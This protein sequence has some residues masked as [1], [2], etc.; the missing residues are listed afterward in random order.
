MMYTGINSDFD[1]NFIEH[2]GQIDWSR[3]Y[4]K[5]HKLDIG[6]KYIFR[7]N[8]S[9]NSRE[10][11]GS[12]STFDD[13][14]H[15]TSIGAA[16][17]DYRVT[18]GRFSARAGLRY[19]FSRLSAKFKA[20]EGSDFGSN[21]SDFA[22][23]VA[24]SWNV[25]DANSLKISYSRRIARPGISYLDPTVNE[26]PNATHQGNP[27]LNSASQ[28]SINLNYGL[29]KSK[30]NVNANLRFDFSNDQIGSLKWYEGLHS[31]STFANIN[32]YRNVE[33]SGY[34][35][36]S[37]G[38]KTTIMLNLSVGYQHYRYPTE[39]LSLSRWSYSPY[40]YVMQRLPWKLRIN[41]A[42]GMWNGMISGVYGYMDNPLSSMWHQI[43]LQRSFLKEDRLTIGITASNPFGPST[44]ESRFRSVNADYTG[45]STSYQ[46]HRR[47]VG[48]SIGYRFGS[49]NVFVKKT[50][51]SIDNDDL[52]GRKQ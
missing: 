3:P 24:L 20:G 27:H 21:L 8:H 23:N 50:A 41:G 12:H 35:Q 11:V 15:R 51:A 25:D 32:H 45:T 40:L 1:L 37:P 14:V 48:L 7:D 42:A 36:W 29:I 38:S 33:L 16:Y 26:S 4:G 31:Y 52:T 49:L 44:S 19:E 46:L 18:F 28:N 39:G 43:S 10:Y 17:A 30:I 9:K 2:T 13:F 47:S 34:M 22:P 5:Q 6:A